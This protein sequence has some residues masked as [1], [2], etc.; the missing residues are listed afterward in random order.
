MLLDLDLPKQNNI[1]YKLTKLMLAI[2]Y[3]HD[4]FIASCFLCIINSVQSLRTRR[5]MGG[6][7]MPR[8]HC[9]SKWTNVVCKILANQGR[10][11]RTV[12]VLLKLLD[13]VLLCSLLT[14]NQLL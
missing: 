12:S 3:S 14:W 1:R 2:L 10:I 11:S 8:D 9:V 7:G 5:Q 13:M 4:S 6:K